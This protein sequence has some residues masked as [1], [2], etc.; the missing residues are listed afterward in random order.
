MNR[1]RIHPA[2]TFFLIQ[3]EK[4]KSCSIFFLSY[5]VRGGQR[6]P[7]GLL[8]QKFYSFLMQWVIPV[9]PNFIICQ[10]VDID[11]FLT[12]LTPT[13]PTH[14]KKEEE[15]KEKSSYQTHEDSKFRNKP[16]HQPSVRCTQRQQEQKGSWPCVQRV[17]QAVDNTYL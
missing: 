16:S 12:N 6:C 2:P 4:A 5:F 17:F 9:F 15:E 13:H 8:S 3:N 7:Q 11:S 1:E 10:L 14:P